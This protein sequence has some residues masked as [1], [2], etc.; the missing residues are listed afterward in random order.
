MRETFT[1]GGPTLYT[2][3]GT[4]QKRSSNT[5]QQ[6]TFNGNTN[7]ASKAVLVVKTLNEGPTLNG[8]NVIKD[9][10]LTVYSQA[11]LRY[12]AFLTLDAHLPGNGMGG[13]TKPVAIDSPTISTSGVT[14]CGVN[15]VGVA[16]TSCTAGACTAQNVGAPKG[17]SDFDKPL[18]CN[19]AANMPAN[20]GTSRPSIANVA[21][22]KARAG[23][24]YVE[25]NEVGAVSEA[26]TKSVNTKGVAPTAD[27]DA[28]KLNRKTAASNAGFT[29]PKAE[30]LTQ[31]S[32]GVVTSPVSGCTNLRA[33]ALG[34]GNSLAMS[35]ISQ[36]PAARVA[37]GT[38]CKAAYAVT[39]TG[40]QT[41][42]GTTSGQ[43]NGVGNA[44]VVVNAAPVADGKLTVVDGVATPYCIGP[45]VGYLTPYYIGT[46]WVSEAAKDTTVDVK[47]ILVP[48]PTPTPA[49]TGVA[50]LPTSSG[51]TGGAYVYGFLPKATTIPKTGDPQDTQYQAELKL[52]KTGGSAGGVLSQGLNPNTIASNEANT[53]VTAAV[54]GEYRGARQNFAYLSAEITRQAT[55]LPTATG[56]TGDA[57]C[58]APSVA[59]PLDITT[60]IDAEPFLP[61]RLSAEEIQYAPLKAGNSGKNMG[62]ENSF[63]CSDGGSSDTGADTL[64]SGKTGNKA[65][66][67]GSGA[68]IKNQL[69]GLAFWKIIA[70]Q[71]N[72]AKPANVEKDTAGNELT[73]S[74]VHENCAANIEAMLTFNTAAIVKNA[75]SATAVTQTS[76]KGNKP[77]AISFPTWK[78]AIGSKPTGQD[79]NYYV[80][81]N[82][83]CY[84][85]QC[86]V[87]YLNSAAQDKGAGFGKLI[88]SPNM[89][90]PTSGKNCG[91]ANGACGS[92][93]LF[94]QENRAP[95]SYT[96]SKLAQDG[97]TTI[98]E[99]CGTNRWTLGANA[100]G[101]ITNFASGTRYTNPIEQTGTA[102]GG[103]GTG[104]NAAPM[105]SSPDGVQYITKTASVSSWNGQ[106][107]PAP[108]NADGSPVV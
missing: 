69:E 38:A 8:I 81:P 24:G 21:N 74:K 53:W 76:V 108:S 28:G 67:N 37:A 7:I 54:N 60:G 95:L 34:V 94:R 48:I 40:P 105:G 29:Y 90:A 107:W 9:S 83:F 36:F 5:G 65:A 78:V 70:G 63:A 64:V 87:T 12:S 57:S 19:I 56:C 22:N 92:I 4:T 35:D 103:V 86:L 10:L 43:R 52:D 88:N 15:Q 101:K 98:P 91:Q 75:N 106:E 2:P 47:N 3:A 31:S 68:A 102:T 55:A 80:V 32:S 25:W 17:E 50:T 61:A 89:G 82:G 49:A 85:N 23:M 45:S 27:G 84:V 73:L 42:K 66:V 33:N 46:N 13:S 97:K 44:Q 59:T 99:E 11:T 41:P 71:M 16:V 72:A 26:Q 77:N 93:A 100:V 79:F 14:A 51:S 39:A 18:C 20:L 96:C 104:A 6:E 58:T 30:Q 62:A 1:T